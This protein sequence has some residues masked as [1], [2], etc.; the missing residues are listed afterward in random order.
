M[1]AAVLCFLEYYLEYYFNKEKRGPRLKSIYIFLCRA[2]LLIVTQHQA[3]RRKPAGATQGAYAHAHAL[4]LA[5]A[6]KAAALYVAQPVSRFGKY[7]EVGVSCSSPS[8]PRR[9]LSLLY[10]DSYQ[11]HSSLKRAPLIIAQGGGHW[12]GRNT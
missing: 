6:A 1:Y 12:W 3:G 7:A 10:C 2:K 5:H 4:N 9:T 8:S 11:R